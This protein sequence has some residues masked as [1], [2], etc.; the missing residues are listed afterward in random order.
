MQLARYFRFVGRYCVRLR[1]MRRPSKT[2]CQV[3]MRL[4]S[5]PQR[6]DGVISM[7][8]RS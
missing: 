1:G 7:M 3:L 2:L 6:A 4:R 8:E 5:S